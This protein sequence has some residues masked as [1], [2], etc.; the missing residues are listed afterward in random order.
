MSLF[1]IFFNFSFSTSDK[2]EVSSFWEVFFLR[3]KKVRKK[4]NKKKMKGAVNNKIF[5]IVKV[6]FSKINSPYLSTKNSFISSLDEPSSNLS[7]TNFFKSRA[8]GASE[9]NNDWF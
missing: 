5:F 7:R 2:I 8:R 6:G 4:P 9:S 3:N 1:N